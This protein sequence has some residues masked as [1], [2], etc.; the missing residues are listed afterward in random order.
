MTVKY[1]L[2][3]GGGPYGHR[4]VSID[5]VNNLTINQQYWLHDY[6]HGYH[7]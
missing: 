6:L 1:H 5:Y 7:K 3:R 2:T 4:P